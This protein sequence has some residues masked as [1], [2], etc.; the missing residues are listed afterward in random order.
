MPFYARID[1]GQVR[2]A[3]ALPQSVSNDVFPG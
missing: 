2:L 3:A 1:L